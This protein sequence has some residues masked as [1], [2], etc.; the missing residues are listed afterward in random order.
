M[1][2]TIGVLVRYGYLVVF[3]SVL[4]EQSVSDPHRRSCWA[5]RPGRSGKLSLTLLL[6]LSGIASLMADMSWYWIGR[7]GG[8]RVLGWLCRISLEP[9]SCVRRTQTIFSK[10]GPRSLVVAKFIPGLQHDR[11][12]AGGHRPDAVEHV[13]GLQ[14]AWGPVLGWRVHHARLVF[15]YQLEIVAE[16]AVQ[17]GSWTLA[18][19]GAALGGYIAWK[20]TSRQR[21]LKKI[22]I[23]PDH[24]GRAQAMLDGG[25]EIL[26]VDVR[27]RIDFEAEPTIISRRPA[28]DDR[29]YRQAPP[30]DPARARDRPVLHLTQRSLQ[31]P[32]GADPRRARIERVPPLAADSGAGGFVG[33]GAIQDD[34]A[35][36]RD[37]L[38]ALVDIFDR[39][40][41]G[42]GNDRRLGLEVDPVAHVD[43]QDL[44]AAVE[45]SLEL[46]RRDPG[47]PDLLEESLA[48][49]ELPGDVA[50]ERG[51]Q[52]RERPA[53]EL[54]G[55]LGDDLELVAETPSRA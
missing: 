55:V 18:L 32:C 43:D 42:A 29:R 40:M 8:A 39:Q 52:Q 6:V 34:L 46:C 35:L 28:S 53:S 27:D 21:F 7:L 9:D 30:G 37:L 45:H 24:A 22:R 20:F 19:L 12:A 51:S 41:Q 36:A 10:H 47:D 38:V 31:R 44:L 5:R 23:V 11:P 17:L 14:R 25:E 2:S 1:D 48:R 4:A 13:R 49:G 50:A 3:G 16:Y 26:I 33:S 15:S 54:H